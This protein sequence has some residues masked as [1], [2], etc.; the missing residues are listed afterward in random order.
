M[1]AP[2]SWPGR[3]VAERCSCPPTPG[4]SDRFRVSGFG[5]GNQSLLTSAAT[6]CWCCALGFRQRPVEPLLQFTS[7]LKTEAIRR[8]FSGRDKQVAALGRK[9]RESI[10]ASGVGRDAPVELAWLVDFNIRARQRIAGGVNDFSIYDRRQRGFD[11]SGL[12]DQLG[13]MTARRNIASRLLRSIKTREVDA[14][15]LIVSECAL[16]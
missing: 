14:T 15:C 7:R 11:D 4:A 12:T 13:L 9:R 10:L 6:G 5:F 16:H 3:P 2:H 8:Q 1:A